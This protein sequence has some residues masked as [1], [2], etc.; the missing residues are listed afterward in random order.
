MKNNILN[1]SIC[2]NLL[3]DKVRNEKYFLLVVASS[4]FAVT[5]LWLDGGK[6]ALRVVSQPESKSS[7]LW[8]KI[9]ILSIDLL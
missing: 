7:F 1:N 6:T 3:L 2:D 8:P 9:K 5:L 4:D